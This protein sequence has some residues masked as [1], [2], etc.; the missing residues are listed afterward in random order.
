[1]SVSLGHHEGAPS[2]VMGLFAGQRRHEW[3]GETGDVI[4]P[5]VVE[6]GNLG[7]Q[8]ESQATQ[9]AI[10]QS[11]LNILPVRWGVQRIDIV[12][13]LALAIP[14]CHPPHRYP[15]KHACASCQYAKAQSSA[16]S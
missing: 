15:V 13:S 9:S 4:L 5:P 6:A 7:C 3:D 11:A 16:Q 12:D 2:V 14:A 10:H 8:V 1:M